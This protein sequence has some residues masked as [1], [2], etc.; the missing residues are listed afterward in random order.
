VISVRFERFVLV[1]AGVLAGVLITSA[2]GLL[3]MSVLSYAAVKEAVAGSAGADVA[4]KLTP[5]L[6]S[7]IAHNLR[8]VTAILMCAGIGLA[9]TAQWI[10]TRI[11]RAAA[12]FHEL[13]AELKAG[14]A[15]IRAEEPWHLTALSTILLAGAAIR[16]RYLFEPMR[17]DEADS[18]L[19]FAS[20][21]F[22]VGLLYYTPNNHI[23]NTVLMRI[24]YLLFGDAPWAL[25][26]PVL[27]AGILVVPLVYCAVRLSA[28]K[29]AALLAAALASMSF[30]LLEYS[31]NAR[32]YVLGTAFLLGMI[33]FARLLDQAPIAWLPAALCATLAVYSVPTTGFGVAGVFVWMAFTRRFR[34]VLRTAVATA[35]AVGVLFLAPLL[36]GALS[37]VQ[38]GPWAVPL[39]FAELASVL[40][41]SIGFLWAYWTMRLPLAIVIAIVCGAVLSIAIRIFDRSRRPSLF[42]ISVVVCTALLFVTRYDPPRR[43]WL[44]L[45]PL[46]LGAAADG[47]AV[48]VRARRM[49]ALLAVAIC[50][51]MG[52]AVLRGGVLYRPGGAEYLFHN[53]DSYGFPNA[54]QLVSDQ[55]SRIERGAEFVYTHPHDVP[56][57]FALFH[58]RIPYQPSPSGDLLIVTER[59]GSPR[60]T[61]EKSHKIEAS[62]VEI[63]RKL[64][65]YQYADL[66]VGKRRN[67]ETS[68]I[69]QSDAGIAPVR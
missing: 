42:L 21:P 2:L 40:P 28:S 19:N 60:K 31:V 44:F 52:V 43:V 63:V 35:L 64:A 50:V 11:T 13:A 37:R 51:W 54:E 69:P 49:A 17:Y 18:F 65:S 10:A 45:L 38:G 46:L 20:R 66:Y 14:A 47:W 33:I 29:N 55:R 15:R 56:I 58:L 57:R 4:G 6:Y 23:L 41:R 39:S 5:E 59:D 12:G 24:S 9:A 3:A 25:R 34:D 1:L 68:A 61:I 36:T 32:G 53:A 27:I 7:H 22:F 67:T 8:M 30:P 48:I 62:D 26:L 16:L